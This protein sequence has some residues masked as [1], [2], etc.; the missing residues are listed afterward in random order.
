MLTSYPLIELP[1]GDFSNT[2]D[3]Q[4]IHMAAAHNMFIQG[5]NA[6][7]AHAPQIKPEKVKPFTFFCLSVLDL[8]H[9][10]HS[11]EETFYFAAMEE[12]LGE[13]ALS[14][15]KEEHSHF[16]PQM[17]ETEEWLKSVHDGREQ[18]D[19]QTFLEHIDSFADSMMEHMKHEPQVLDRHKLRETFTEK[20]L[21]DIDRD[22]MKHALD[23][24]DY[25][26]TLPIS[27]VCGNPATP[28]FPPLPLPLKWATRWW[29]SRRHREAWEFGTLD[30]AGKPRQLPSSIH[31]VNQA[32]GSI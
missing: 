25:Y 15:S 19:A 26:T 13:G 24:I 1:P 12:G 27:I 16:V 31:S 8:I 30:L 4:A 32:G 3:S 5:I 29:F 23:G 18:Y 28:W 17:K 10:H 22:F 11:L 9:H 14:G 6:M 21:K 20:R 7:V 2:F